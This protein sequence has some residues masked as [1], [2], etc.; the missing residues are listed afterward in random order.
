M[1]L[2]QATRTKALQEAYRKAEWTL[3]RDDVPKAGEVRSLGL[4]GKEENT[5][6]VLGR[7]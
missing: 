3:A 7:D 6:K 4:L 5:R 1:D 2:S